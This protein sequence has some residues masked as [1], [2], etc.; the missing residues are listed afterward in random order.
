M[1]GNGPAA[2]LHGQPTQSCTGDRQYTRDH[3]KKEGSKIGPA[4]GEVISEF[5]PH[6]MNSAE[7]P[8]QDTAASPETS[9]PSTNSTC[10]IIEP[11]QTLPHPLRQ[12]SVLFV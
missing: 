4:L 9:I 3:A 6:M 2:P 1:L 5:S 7:R 10:S 11:L 12:A 8:Q